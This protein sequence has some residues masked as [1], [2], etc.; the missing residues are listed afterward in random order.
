MPPAEY[1]RRYP[2][3]GYWLRQ[4]E[5]HPFINPLPSQRQQPQ[6]EP[7][8]PRT[9]PPPYQ[10]RMPPQ[11]GALPQGLP[12]P[13]AEHP[14]M[15]PGAPL[16]G[17]VGQPG[18]LPAHAGVGY[19]FPPQPPAPAAPAN[20]TQ[21][22]S[23][24]DRVITELQFSLPLNTSV[25]GA[26]IERAIV[27]YSCNVTFADWWTRTCQRMAL[28]PNEAE[29]GWK[30]DSHRAGDAPIRIASDADLHIAID[31]GRAKA[32]RAIVNQP[33]I[34]VY[35]LKPATE[36]PATA[37]RK[38]RATTDEDV[39]T[40]IDAAPQLR[41]LKEHMACAKHH[42]SYCFVSRPSGE[43]QELDIYMLTLWARKM[44]TNEATLQEPPN[45]IS[46]DRP[47]AKK[48]RLSASQQ[49]PIEIHNHISAATA[50]PALLSDR[51]GEHTVNTT[52][53]A[54]SFP[55]QLDDDDDDFLVVYPSV[56]LALRELDAVMPDAGFRHYEAGFR[57]HGIYYVD[58][59]QRESDAWLKATLGMEHGIIGAFREHIRRLVKRARK[60]KNRAISVKVENDENSP[61]VIE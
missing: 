45:F 59:A 38:R 49:A 46:F 14:P 19:P 24:R 43:H 33:C 48:P 17:A 41:A 8:T 52:P 11:P 1:R 56:T 28:D 50:P 25:V 15:L 36:A 5:D 39:A 16:P 54:S 61:I 9:P 10:P 37:G 53:P 60:G 51:G 12:P 47:P 6:Q 26:R 21:S 34:M 13:Y 58:A 20:A 40:R 3:M 4:F 23:R 18:Y 31:A 27:M 30:L 7:R 29:L 22:A 55:G 35:N 2:R 42:G 32:Q 44:A 57:E